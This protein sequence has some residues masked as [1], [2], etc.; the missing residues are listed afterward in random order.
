MKKLLFLTR[1]QKRAV[2]EIQTLVTKE[3]YYVIIVL[4]PFSDKKSVMAF[5]LRLK[6]EAYKDQTL[7]HCLRSEEFIY[8]VGDINQNPLENLLL[9]R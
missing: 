3:N 5:L 8:K 4:F 6:D 1:E 2:D 7:S 9:Y